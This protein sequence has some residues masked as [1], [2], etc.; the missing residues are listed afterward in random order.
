ME[1][2]FGGHK[3]FYL[4]FFFLL[5]SVLVCVK[6]RT[7]AFINMNKMKQL[8]GKHKPSVIGNNEIE[9]RQVKIV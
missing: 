1:M 7:I 4:F 6:K 3:N 8:K 9:S 5:K 2:A